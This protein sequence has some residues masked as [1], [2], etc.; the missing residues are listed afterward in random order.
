MENMDK[1]FTNIDAN[2]IY[3]H[4]L[5]YYSDVFYHYFISLQCPVIREY[6]NMPALS[7]LFSECK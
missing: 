4:N 7:Y 2:N 1:S 6:R 3:H 5:C